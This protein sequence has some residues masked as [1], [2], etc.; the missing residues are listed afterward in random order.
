MTRVTWNSGQGRYRPALGEETQ[1]SRFVYF[2]LASLLVSWF[3]ISGHFPRGP[4]AGFS[5]VPGNLYQCVN[6]FNILITSWMWHMLHTT[7][8]FTTTYVEAIW[9]LGLCA[10]GLSSHCL[11]WNRGPAW[12]FNEYICM[13]S[14]S[15]SKSLILYSTLRGSV[16]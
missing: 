12:V 1:E 16:I 2:E 7:Y 15:Q 4:C 9:F 13:T 14:S 5:S 10:A 11:G 8:S 6:E 3:L